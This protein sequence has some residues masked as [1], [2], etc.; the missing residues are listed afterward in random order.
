MMRLNLQDSLL[1]PTRAQSALAKNKPL[2]LDSL[3]PPL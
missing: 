1:I 3:W 2:R